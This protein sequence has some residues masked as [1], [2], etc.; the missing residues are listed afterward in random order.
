MSFNPVP[1]GKRLIVEHVTVFIGV[2]SGGQPNYLTFGDSSV[3]NSGNVAIVKPDFSIS[4]NVG[5]FNFWALDRDALVYYE[6]GATPKLKIG[7]TANFG[8]VGNA[9]LHGYLIDAAN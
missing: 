3:T 1:A 8:F 5:G 7:A 9:S 6:A 4:N 2:A